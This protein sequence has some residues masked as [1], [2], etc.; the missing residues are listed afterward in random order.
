METVMALVWM[1]IS[2]QHIMTAQAMPVD[3]CWRMA[4]TMA[5]NNPDV[6]L[7]D[8]VR[9]TSK[10]EA[11]IDARIESHDCTPIEVRENFVNFTCRKG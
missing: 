11:Y 7:V 3:L 8:C 1:T 9:L 10:A 6:K 5:K 2:G 4:A